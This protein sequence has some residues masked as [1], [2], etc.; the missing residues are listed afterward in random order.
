MDNKEFAEQVI[1]ALSDYN[2]A[3]KIGAGP[4]IMKNSPQSGT[5]NGVHILM[6][7]WWKVKAK[8]YIY[9]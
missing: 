9:K 2:F 5:K 6:F 7:C 8:R 4:M 1:Y 3:E